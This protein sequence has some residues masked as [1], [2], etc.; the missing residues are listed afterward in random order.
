[1][2]RKDRAG[3]GGRATRNLPRFRII[4]LSS[5]VCTAAWCRPGAEIQNLPESIEL[6]VFGHVRSLIVR[7]HSRAILYG[8][9]DLSLLVCRRG[10]S[11]ERVDIGRRFKIFQL[12]LIDWSYSFTGMYARP[13]ELRID[14]PREIMRRKHRAGWGCAIKGSPCRISSYFSL[15]LSLGRLGGT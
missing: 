9:R 4:S 5:A 13:P 8:P 6:V 3:C 11:E 2:R 10:C 15:S 14:S 12:E 1:M 7:R